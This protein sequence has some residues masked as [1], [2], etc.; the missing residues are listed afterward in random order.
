MVT[1]ISTK[2]LTQVDKTGGTISSVCFYDIN[3]NMNDNPSIYHSDVLSDEKE[4]DGVSGIEG[5][6]IISHDSTKS[7]VELNN[8]GDLSISVEGDLESNY[9]VVNENL[10]YN[11]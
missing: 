8:D 11:G 5:E 9:Q 4:I 10:E 6:L 1:E 2:T 7:E 3:A